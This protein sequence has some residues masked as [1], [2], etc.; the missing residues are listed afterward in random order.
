MPRNYIFRIPLA[1]LSCSIITR[2]LALS[3]QECVHEPT[4]VYDYFDSFCVNLSHE[5]FLVRTTDQSKVHLQRNR[6]HCHLRPVKEGS[7]GFWL[8]RHNGSLLLRDAEIWRLALL[9]QKECAWHEEIWKLLTWKARF[10]VQKSQH[11]PIAIRTDR[12][13]ETYLKNLI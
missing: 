2:Y 4:L 13:A 7:I 9:L 3:T 5:L 10:L 8:A 1:I 12:S 11:Q 6:G